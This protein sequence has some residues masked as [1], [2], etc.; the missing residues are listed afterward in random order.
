VVAPSGT[1][2]ALNADF[3]SAIKQVV[4]IPVICVGR[5]NT[6]RIAEF[7]IDTGKADM[8]CMGRALLCDPELPNKARSGNLDDIAPCIAC[9]VG[10][11]GTVVKGSP[12]T[13]VMNPAAGREREM[14]LVPAETPK[15]VLVIGAGPA[16]LEAATVAAQRGHTVTLYE[17]KQ[18][19]GG[20]VNLASVPPFMQEVSQLIKY[21]AN[22]AQK[23]GVEVVLGKEVTRELIDQ[24]KPDV[25]IVATGSTPLIP[26]GIPGIHKKNVVT[27]WDILGGH[28]AGLAR[29]VV[30][31][32]GGLVG[33]ETADYLAQTKDVLGI[34][35]TEVTIVEMEGTIAKDGVSEARHL[36]MERL[37]EKEVTILLKSQVTE[38]LDD[39]VIYETEAPVAL[40]ERHSRLPFAETVNLTMD[41]VYNQ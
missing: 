1:P 41:L 32:G 6:P 8:T 3:A 33:C 2:L 35:T 36:L 34:S 5:I 29:Q 24:L 40:T 13:C 7:V 9:N 38:I 15:Q 27:A 31:I 28:K 21:Q 22:Q 14:A 4:D 25:A 18:K 39:G 11:I 12:A 37:R 16:G 17:K 19:L 30:I 23:A 26:E 20:Q 10:C